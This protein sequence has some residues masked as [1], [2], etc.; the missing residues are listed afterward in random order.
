[1]ATIG[2]SV[3]NGG[4]N[5]R[6]DVLAIQ[7]LINQCIG[8]LVPRAPLA[9]NGVCDS[10]TKDAITDF[11]QRVV[12]ISA[13]DGR[14]DPGGHTLEALN[15]VASGKPYV[16]AAAP[17]ATGGDGKKYTD[18]PLEMIT[19]RTTPTARD[20]VAMLRSSWAQLSEAGART[21]TAQFMAE[22]GGGKYCFNWNLGNVKSGAGEPHMYLRGVWEVD[23]PTGAA[24]QVARAN[25]LAHVAT[26]DEI[27]KHGWSCPSGKAV[28][29]FD[30]PHPQCRFRAYVSLRDGAQKW[31]GHHQRI[32]V[33]N[34]TYLASLNAGN[35]AAVAHALKLAG[36]YTAGEADYARAMT[37]TKA[38]V[39]RSLGPLS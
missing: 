1:M 39:D 38:E 30:P 20:V 28:A 19:R 29:V 13:P 4:K 33:R 2:G 35:V 21:L 16:P 3:G 14:V 26:A 15:V 18:S 12:K 6:N 8:S 34:S 31:L 10:A 17:P 36:Y 24:G 11:Q 27:K 7:N 22:T 37:K 32:A 25:G 23:S 9:A 5:A